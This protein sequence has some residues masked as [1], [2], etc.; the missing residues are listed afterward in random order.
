MTREE[1][2]ASKDPDDESKEKPRRCTPAGIMNLPNDA[3]NWIHT[4]GDAYGYKLLVILFFSQWILKGFVYMF[5]YTSCDWLLRSYHVPG[6]KM[7]IYKSLMM[8]PASMKPVWGIVSD[9][10]PIAGYH[11]APYML[12]SSAVGIAGLAVVGFVP[13]DSLAL[14]MAVGCLFCGMAQVM[15]CDLMT[16]AKYAERM[17]ENPKY[18]P[19]LMSYVWMGVF[20]GHLVA[21]AC[22]GIILESWGPKVMLGLCVIPAAFIIL[23]ICMNYMDEK[24]DTPEESVAIRQRFIKQTEVLILVFLMACATLSMVAVGLLQDNVWVNLSVALTMGII[25]NVAFFMLTRP[26]IGKMNCYF[27]IQTALTLN[28]EGAMFYFFTDGPKQYPNGPHFSIMFYTTGIGVI[29]GFFNLVGIWTYNNFGRG[30]R[31]HRLFFTTNVLYSCVT[32][33]SVLVYSRYNL[34]IGIPDTAFVVGSTVVQSIVMQWMW[35]PGV[36]LLSQLCPKSMEA[37]M[38]ALLAG[39]HNLGQG[40]GSYTGAAMMQYFGI[41]PNGSDNEGGKFHWLWLMALIAATLPC[42]TLVL[43]P[44]MIPNAYQTDQLIH[45]NAN[46]TGGSYWRRLRGYKDDEEEEASMSARDRER[47]G[48]T[49][50][51]A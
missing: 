39:C 36:V 30:W 11:R 29:L 27:F 26:I 50:S 16:E 42:L 43:L 33:T 21:T 48:A 5:I 25:V 18:G 31:Y 4:L 7:Q 15:I 1:K 2:I 12:I 49:S 10:L 6:P 45:D 24:K 51:R 35:I 22:T 47:Y 44:Y 17:R 9:M 28:M 46:A 3:V 38:Y 19:D 13:H 20:L 32:L 23:P 40:V 41:T 37:T 34:K 8:L 14:Q